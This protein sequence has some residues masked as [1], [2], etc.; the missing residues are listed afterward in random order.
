[1]SYVVWFRTGISYLFLFFFGGTIG[2]IFLLLS[3]TVKNSSKM[4]IR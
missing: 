1:M 3:Q 4:A 2:N